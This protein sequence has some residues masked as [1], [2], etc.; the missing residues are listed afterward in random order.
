VDKVSYTSQLVEK[1][2]ANEMNGMSWKQGNISE[3]HRQ[4]DGK[5]GRF[6]KV[7]SILPPSPKELKEAR[8]FVIADYQDYLD[9]L[10]VE[11]LK[12]EFKVNVNQ[13]VF[14]SLIKH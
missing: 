10:W 9:K 14:N 2:N 13:N 8:G 7:E 12:N 4:P 1:S 11:K 3:L 5:L 6:D